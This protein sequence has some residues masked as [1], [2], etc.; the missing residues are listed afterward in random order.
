MDFFVHPNGVCESTKIGRG[1]RIWAFAHILPN[2]IIG[3]DCNIC[4]HVFI[5]NDVSIGN[6]VTIKSGTQLWDGITLEDDVFVGPNATFTNDLMPRSKKYPEI[7]LAT[8]VCEGASIGAN[9]TILPGLRI[10]K[11]SMVGAGSVVTKDVPDFAIVTGNPARISGY[12]STSS[13]NLT[14]EI[15]NKTDQISQVKNVKLV[16][17]STAIDLRGSLVAGEVDKQ[18][19]FIPKRFFTIFDVPSKESRGAHAHKKC[20]QFLVC[21][22]GS[23]RAI[24]DD[25]NIR[26]EFTL[27]SPSDGLYLPAG[28]WGTQ[29]RYSKNAVLLVLASHEYDSDDYIRDYE[30]FLK[31]VNV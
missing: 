13:K 20:D 18:I 25:G 14:A 22:S 31:F 24:V 11:H 8:T 7:F 17:L 12:V 26:E 4:D 16:K 19:P 28:T 3:E 1:T 15:Q 2:A 23:V 5:E 27:S 10:G 6:R 29:Y 21:L 30:E 9:A